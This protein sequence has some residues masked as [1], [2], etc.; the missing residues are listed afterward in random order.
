LIKSGRLFVDPAVG[1]SHLLHEA[2][3]LALLPQDYRHDAGM[4]PEDLVPYIYSGVAALDL[5][6]DHPLMRALIQVS[7]PEATAWAWAAGLAAGL[8]PGQI[9][10]AREY[11][12]AGRDVREQ[13]S[14]GYYAG[15]HGLAHAGF[16]RL[17]RKPGGFPCML[18]W[19]QDATIES[20]FDRG[21][22]KERQ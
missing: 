6:P 8:A 19:L 17:A 10:R 15:I 13:V 22:P 18:K 9:I 16:C 20:P 2:G 4:D 3:H 21:H 12:G 1:A 7:D 5:H 11:D 14:S